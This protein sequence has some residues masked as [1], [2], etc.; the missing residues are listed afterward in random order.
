MARQE[1]LA[2]ERHAALR[3]ALAC[4][5]SC[6]QQ[7]ILLH[8][9]RRGPQADRLT[10]PATAQRAWLVHKT[11]VTRGAAAGHVGWARRAAAHPLVMAALA[12]GT[13]LTEP[14]ARK[15]CGWT[16]QLPGDCRAA[17]DEILVAAARAGA[18]ERDLAGLAAEI[19]ARAPRD[20]DDGPGRF[21]D[22]CVRLETTFDG[23]GVLRGDLSPECAAVVG[24][25]LDA[26]AV[27]A[28]A[29]DTR[30]RG[31]RYHDALEEAARRLVAGG[32]LPGRAGQPVRAW[33]HVPLAELRA[34]DHGSKLEDQWVT[35]MRARWAAH[36]AAASISGGDGAAWLD[37]DAARAA[38]C[39]ATVIPVVTGEPDPGVLDDLVRLCTQLAGHGHHG[40][41][42]GPGTPGGRESAGRDSGDGVSGGRDHDSGGDS[43]S[44]QPLTPR[45]REALQQAIIGKAI[46]LVSGPGGLASFLRRRVLD[47]RLAGPSVPL[48]VGV[49]STI[50][51][52]IRA[53]VILR[54]Q[55]CQWAGGCDQ[56]A[57]GCQVHHIRH[58]ANGGPTSVDGCSLYCTFHHLIAIHRWGW[59]VQRHPDGTSTAYSP[60]G[61]KVLHSHGPPPRPG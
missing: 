23:A 37:G 40:Q 8:R 22:R 15:L 5:S 34:L 36:R 58:Q 47:G 55:H 11:R 51:A 44:T 24:A 3:E 14:V 9:R 52:A 6:C 30:T 39:D 18:G 2:A 29:Q 42:A 26:L 35:T 20:Q 27:R 12:E 7:L 49:S 46:D 1:L 45:G 54:D 48:D 43:I 21:E 31:Q 32:L 56:P 4:F 50:P 59:T 19:R 10:D 28:G 41:Q 13:V 17:A 53:A 38:A 57:A 25:V 60:D 16:D 33:V 61:T